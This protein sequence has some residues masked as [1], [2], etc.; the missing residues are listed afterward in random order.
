VR[1]EKNKKADKKRKRF[2]KKRLR[3]IIRGWEKRLQGRSKKTCLTGEYR[4]DGGGFDCIRLQRGRGRRN[5]RKSVGA[6]DAEKSK[7]REKR[8]DISV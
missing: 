2:V 5:E 6:D 7:Q 3:Q 8:K 1:G 4:G